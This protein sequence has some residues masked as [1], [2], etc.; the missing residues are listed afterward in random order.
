MDETFAVWLL[1]SPRDLNIKYPIYI[2]HI[3]KVVTSR[4]SDQLHQAPQTGRPQRDPLKRTIVVLIIPISADVRASLS[5]FG[6]FVVRNAMLA[7]NTTVI[8]A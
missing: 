1:D 3:T 4:A 5:H 7:M 6:F 2:S 8:D